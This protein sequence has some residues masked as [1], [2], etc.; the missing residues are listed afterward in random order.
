MIYC[1][2]NGENCR[3][4]HTHPNSRG[5]ITT[6]FY[7]GNGCVS[8]DSFSLEDFKDVKEFIESRYK[9]FKLK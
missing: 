4:Q 7:W 5:I 9:N 6:F 1:Q 8:P 2:L 3:V